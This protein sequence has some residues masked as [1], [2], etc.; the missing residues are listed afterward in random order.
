MSYDL[1]GYRPSS[2]LPNIEEARAV[3]S[4]EEGQPRRNDEESRTINRKIANA[5][6]DHNPRLEEFN[7]DFEK[8]AAFDKSTV[9]AAMARW[10]HIE[11]N[12]PEDDLAIQLTVY[13]DHVDLAIPYWYKEDEAAKIFELAD[14]YLK[15]I[16]NTAGFFAYDPQEDR[17]FDPQ[18]EGFGSHANYE[19]ITRQV[20]T[21]ASNYVSTTKKPWWKFW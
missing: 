14:G 3:I 15:V 1:Y 8:I 4:T 11:L 9:E 5:I 7:P 17:A 12:P 19:R 6:L 13:G 10:N 18:K 20:P 2:A 16:R 21:I